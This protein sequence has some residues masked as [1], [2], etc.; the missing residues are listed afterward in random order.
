MT[1][2]VLVTGAGKRIGRALALGLA[3]EGHPIA[4]HHNRSADAANEVVDIIRNN[5][6]TAAP[7][8]ADLSDEQA[9]ESLIGEV[10]DKLGEPGALINNASAFEKDDLL[11]AT[12][13]N[14]DL[15]FN[16]NLRAPFLLTQAFARTLSSNKKGSIINI[17]DHRVW[18]LNPLFSTY[19]LSK[20]ALWTLTQT[21]AQA[22][23]PRIRVNAIGPGPVLP[24]I[25]QDGDSFSDEASSTL[26]GHG[27][28]LEEIVDTVRF[29]LATPSLTGQM[30]ALDGGQHLA[31]R[32]PDVDASGGH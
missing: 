15:H 5:G 27:P 8:H 20:A 10:K 17:I 1:Y 26:L 14:W 7:F 16:V 31:W 11:T 9:V 25:H 30:I 32:T 3:A 19:T 6:G 18:K 13:Q 23:A 28:S 22:L 12:R 2:P 4:V 21:S 24:S 29:L